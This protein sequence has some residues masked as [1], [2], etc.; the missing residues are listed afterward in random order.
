[1]GIMFAIAISQS[2]EKNESLKYYQIEISCKS[3]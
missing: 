3:H 1:M 2:F